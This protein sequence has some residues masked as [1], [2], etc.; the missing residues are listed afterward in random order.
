MASCE[1]QGSTTCSAGP[2]TTTT[3]HLFVA[4]TSYCCAA[5]TSVADNQGNSYANSIADTA[6]ASGG[7]IR[8]DY[9]A[10]GTGGASHTFTLTGSLST[11]FATLSVIEVSGATAS[12]LDQTAAAAT[13]FGTSHTSPTTSTTAQANELLIGFGGG[14]QIT[15]F[16]NDGGAGWTERTNVATDADS[17]GII[18]SSQVVSAASGYAYTFTTGTATNPAGAISTWK[19]SVAVTRQRCIG[20]GIDKKVIGE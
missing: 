2:I 12:P 19:E 18:V 11:F 8:Q 4:S 7:T 1:A 16:V 13:A 3:G 20:C 10:S 15:T 17:E 6:D 14:I 9:T 5:F